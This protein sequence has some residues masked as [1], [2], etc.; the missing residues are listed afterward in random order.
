MAVEKIEGK[1]SAEQPK[2][3]AKA[4]T[5]S[6]PEKASKFEMPWFRPEKKTEAAKIDKKGENAPVQAIPPAVPAWQSQRAAAIDTILSEGLNE[7]FLKMKPA[8]QKVFQEKGEETVSKINELLS[9]TKIHVTKI[10]SLIRAWLKM[11][12]GI[13]KFFLEQEAKIKA[14][15][16][17]RLKDK[18]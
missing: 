4:E 6:R 18:I 9:K 12:P 8:E 3:A 11:I 17:L 14:D 16:I 7:I 10:I 2:P 13:N 15:K 5:I 1:L